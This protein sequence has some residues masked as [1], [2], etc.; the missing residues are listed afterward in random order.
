MA[1]VTKPTPKELGYTMPGEFEKHAGCWMGWPYDGN[2]WRDNAKPAQLQYAAIAKAISEFE[3]LTMFAHPGEPAEVAREM[4]KDAPNVTVV[5][6][7]IEDGWTRDWGPSCVAKDDSATGKRVVAGVHWDYD[8]Y[9]GLL[10]KKLGLPTMMPSWEKDYN[11]GRALL[12]MNGLEVFEAPIHLEGGSIHSDGQGTLMCTEECL[13]HASRNPHLGK[14]GIEKVL[15]D[16]LGLEKIIWFWRGIMGD[17]GVVNGHVDNFCCFVRPGVVLLAWTD[18]KDDP[19][20]EVSMDAY[21]R[22][23]NTTDAKGRKLEIIKLPRPPPLFRTFKEA[24]GLAEGYIEKGYVP[25]IAGERLPSTY[26]NHYCANGGVV[27][28]QFGG[29]AAEADKRALE[30]IQEA[31]GPDYKVVGVSSREVVLNAGNIHCITQQ[32]PAAW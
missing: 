16:Y 24:N 11:A 21:E 32:H 3:P 15:K 14:E 17:D 13:L 31:Y 28:P 12:E 27:V 1:A 22:L 5:E 10:K 6:L 9:G 23:S 8:C 19:Q 18:D 2:L 30:I 26:I 20:Y 29:V 4:L 25:R 7:E